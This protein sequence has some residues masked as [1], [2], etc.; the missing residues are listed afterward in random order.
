MLRLILSIVL[1]AILYKL[2]HNIFCNFTGLDFLCPVV[3]VFSA[4]L[5]LIFRSSFD[6]KG[7]PSLLQFIAVAILSLLGFTFIKVVVPF[8]VFPYPMNATPYSLSGLPTFESFLQITPECLRSVILFILASITNEN[9]ANLIGYLFAICTGDVVIGVGLLQDTI[10]LKSNPAENTSGLVGNGSGGNGSG[11]G[12][13]SGGNGSGSGGNV[14]G[15]NGS[16][17]NVSGSGGNVSGLGGNSSSS[18]GVGNGTGNPAGGRITID[19]L[20]N[21]VPTKLG[22]DQSAWLIIENKSISVIQ[23]TN[24]RSFTAKD[25]LDNP[26]LTALEKSKLKEFFISQSW[27]S[28]T[29]SIVYGPSV[30]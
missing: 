27:Y 5:A 6:G 19:S 7:N 14:S 15:G 30:G 21:N 1:I 23:N 24:Q 4:I 11:S 3:I 28:H 17:G 12:S 20:L 2:P 26:R 25:L 8:V 9:L 29:S 10:I 13:G 16:G 18:G 22:L